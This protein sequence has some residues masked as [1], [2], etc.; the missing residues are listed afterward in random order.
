[1]IV[2]GAQSGPAGPY[3]LSKTA[4]TAPVSITDI[5]PYAAFYFLLLPHFAVLLTI[6]DARRR[7]QAVAA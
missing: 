3:T 1:M 7:S 6:S 5:A 2:S 4:G